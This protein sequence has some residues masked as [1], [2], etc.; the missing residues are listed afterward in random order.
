MDPSKFCASGTKYSHRYISCENDVKL[1]LIHFKPKI[2]SNFPPV[3][4]IPGWGSIINSWEVVLKEMTKDFEVYYLET[5]EKNSSIHMTEQPITIK[6]MAD[7]LPYILSE[8]NLLSKS[9]ILL[10]SSL[11]AT[12][13]VD[14]ISRNK[15]SPTL[16]ILIG[17]NAEFNIPTLWLIIAR[18]TPPFFFY[19]IRPII[20]WYIKNHYL[21]MNS[22]P[23]QYYKYAKSLD[24][25]SPGRLRR[26]AL[27]FSSYK[28]WD[29]LDK[30]NHAVL[31]LT[32]SK[33]IMHDYKNTLKISDK[34]SNSKLID[35]KTN[36]K[37]HSIEMV[38]KIR[39]FV[40]SN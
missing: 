3:I 36:N 31:I 4:F 20:K 26:S 37:T 6:S 24:Q 15:V 9:Y 1:F 35:M 19:F 11:G 14:S 33:D 29:K 38:V 10:G 7:D 25:A 13:I 12:I 40:N 28:I 23:K 21:D 17:P 39:E 32:G 16:S 27:S 30:V 18:L 8:L 5:R 34:L 22:D 2:K